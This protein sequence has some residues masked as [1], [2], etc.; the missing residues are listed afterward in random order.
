MTPPF[1]L[2]GGEGYDF[3]AGGNRQGSGG[4]PQSATG[5]H[6]QLQ[7]DGAYNYTYDGEGDTL[8][9]TH[10][11]NG[12]V[13]EYTWDHRNRLR[14]VTDRVSA[15]GSVTQRVDYI[16]DAFDQRIGKRLDADGNSSFEHYEAFVW[17]EGQTVLR[18][19]DSDGMD[20]TEPFRLASRYL[21]SSNSRRAAGTWF[22]RGFGHTGFASM[23]RS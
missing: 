3:D 14:S 7:T 6:N 8:T 9:R 13:T 15:S 10:I 21:W 17:A 12:S 1:G 18:F 22:L 4:T 11:T 23:S 16:Y 19:T 2:P 20:S 5:T